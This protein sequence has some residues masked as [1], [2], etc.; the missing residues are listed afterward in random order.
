MFTPTGLQI[1]TPDNVRLAYRHISSNVSWLPRI[2][3]AHDR[4]ISKK[5]YSVSHFP[6]F[7]RV[8]IHILSNLD[9]FFHKLTYGQSSVFPLKIPCHYKRF[10]RYGTWSTKQS[11]INFSNISNICKNASIRLI[12]SVCHLLSPAE[13]ISIERTNRNFLLNMSICSKFGY[14]LTQIRETLR[15]CRHHESCLLTGH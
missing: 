2:F 6:T 9:F 13:R 11:K 5:R 8:W 4:F 15:F 12:I 3:G 1:T 14:T 7:T 10:C